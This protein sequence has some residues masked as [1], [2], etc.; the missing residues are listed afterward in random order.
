MQS[1]KVPGR[2][3]LRTEIIVNIVLLMG[4]ALL[5]SG[6][7]LIKLTERELLAQRVRSATGIMEVLARAVSLTNPEGKD[8]AS[9]LVAGVAQLVQGLQPE[10]TMQGWG[11]VGRDLNLL[12][13]QGPTSGYRLE[14]KALAQVRLSRQ[15]EARV[16]YRSVW[17]LTGPSPESYV[18]ITV[19]VL[20]QGEFLGALQARFPLTEVGR[21]VASAQQLMLLFALGYGTVLVLFGVY[22]LGRTVI[23]P[24]RRLQAMSQRIAAGDLEQA[25][26][27]EGPREIAELAD[28]FNRMATALR[29]GHQ[30][31]ET[32]ILALQRANAEV[33]QAQGELI[34]SEK[35]ASVG[36]L[37]AGMAHEIGNP[38]GAVLGY[39]ELLKSEFPPGREREIVERALTETGRIDRLVRELLDYATPTSSN[40]QTFDPAAA[41]AEARDILRHQGT[42]DGLTLDDRLPPSLPPIVMVR[43]RLVQVCINLMLNARDAST[44]GGPIRL[45]GGVEGELVFLAVADAGAGMSRDTIAHL[46]DPFFTTKAPG[47][48]RGL[49]LAVCQRAIDEAGGRIEVRS[50]PGTGSEFT[51]WLKPAE[52]A[53]HDS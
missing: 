18:V 27:V 47:K 43:H 25:V 1:I 6:F 41:M 2:I 23:R 39:L 14:Q 5:L 10:A 29:L 40:L 37:A 38:L 53:S 24:I 13:E 42:F 32:Y 22:F 36:H 52:S 9:S 49:G 50:T 16:H 7:L 45:S 15:P 19:P 33:R 8:S 26:P 28:A 44:P 20:R 34:R 46:F 51:V 21:R 48:G 30:E 3:G 12:A 4:A 31:R 17:Q 35:M 11:A